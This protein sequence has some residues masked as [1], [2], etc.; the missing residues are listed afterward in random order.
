MS[1]G[2]ALT[3]FGL[4]ELVLVSSVAAVFYYKKAK[5]KTSVSQSPPPPANIV[6]SNSPGAE[7]ALKKAKSEEQVQHDLI[8]EKIELCRK[9][10]LL[11]NKHE[12]RALKLR[13]DLLE[14][15]QSHPVEQEPDEDYWQDLNQH[16]QASLDVEEQNKKVLGKELAPLKQFKE[17]NQ[18]EL[19]KINSVLQT[20]NESLQALRAAFPK[21]DNENRELVTQLESLDVSHAQ[22]LIH[23]D[24]LQLALED[25]PHQKNT[26]PENDSTS[27]HNL[28]GTP[29]FQ[30]FE[31]QLACSPD[32]QLQQNSWQQDDMQEH[33]SS[34]LR[35]SLAQDRATVGKQDNPIVQAHETDLDNER[36]ET[37]PQ[38]ILAPAEQEPEIC[39]DIPVLNQTYDPESDYPEDG[40]YLDIS[41]E[42]EQEHIS[43]AFPLQANGSELSG[44]DIPSILI[45]QNALEQMVEQS[46]DKP[47]FS[48]KAME[49]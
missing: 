16:F 37:L 3:L 4:L 47:K 29:A 20:Q 36:D 17:I 26:S 42:E 13:I 14:F 5:Q 21:A 31:P 25:S 48:P 40:E 49:A 2:M 27:K 15:E 32:A 12:R 1:T 34:A 39:N 43:L 28:D 44:S 8:Q 24:N 30:S 22:L 41:A 18:T 10:M 9:R 11:G 38:V 19:N 35:S 45:Q 33:L 6:F 7:Q 23:M 46:L